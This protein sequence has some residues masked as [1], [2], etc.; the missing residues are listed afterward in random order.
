MNKE[1]LIDACAAVIGMMPSQ[2][3]SHQFIRKFIYNFPSSYGKLLMKHDNVT[4]AHGE[5]AN[6]LRNNSIKLRIQKIDEPKC[7]S[8]DIFDNLATCATWS[9]FSN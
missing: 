2:F 7:E 8:V 1:E 3:N 6:V 4:T 5:I 9:K